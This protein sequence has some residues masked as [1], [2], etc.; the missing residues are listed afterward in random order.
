MASTWSSHPRIAAARRRWPAANA[1]VR[2]MERF[3]IHRTG[4]NS[5]LVAH[6]GFLSVFPLMLVFTTVLGFLLEDNP[7]LRADIIDSAISRIP[8]IG[9]QVATNP[10]ALEG[11]VPVLVFG[12]LTVL[13]AGLKAFNVLQMAL[14]DI[15]DVP[16]DERPNILMIRVKSLLGILI[17]GGSQVA[18]AVLTSY[19]GVSG[20]QLLSRALLFLAAFALNAAV[21]AATYHF[22]CSRRPTWRSVT[23]GAIAGGFVFAV[24]QIIGTTLVSRA[25]VRATP[26]YGTFASVIGLMMW[27]SLHAIVALLGAELNGVLPMHPMATPAASTPDEST[28]A[29]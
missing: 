29:K 28:R 10:A 6:Y 20:V 2:A 13:W 16:L 3:Q 25:I 5:A 26:V 8:I 12:L 27:L 18:A 4:R 15:A 24:L 1:L 22:L 17:I 14:D 11:S 23:P 21:L 7:T 9:P 19:A